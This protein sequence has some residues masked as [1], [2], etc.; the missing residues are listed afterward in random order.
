MR[1]I[2]QHSPRRAHPTHSD[3]TEARHRAAELR[4]LIAEHDHRY[5]VLN[6]PVIAD[7]TYDELKRE[8]VGIEE[9]FRDL[10]TSDSPTRHIGGRPMDGFAKLQHETPML[11]LRSVWDEEEIRH[12]Y[13]NCCRE[14][15]TQTCTLVGESKLDGTSVELTYDDGHLVSASTRGDGHY[16]EDVT[17]NIQMIRDVPLIL[18][19]R[20]AFTQR[21]EKAIPVPRHLVVRGEVFMHKSQFA[22][23][24]A[25][26]T[27]LGEKT[28]ATPR[29]AAAGSLLHVDPGITAGRFLHI[30]F[31]EMAP[32]TQDRPATQWECL[33]AMRSLGLNTDPS[34]VRLES[35]DEA[36][37]WFKRMMARRERFPNEVDGCVFKIDDLAAQQQLGARVD[38]PRWAVAWKF[39]PLQYMTHVERIQTYV[40]RAGIL[41]PVA[42]LAPVRIGG[43]EVS[44]VALGSQAEIERNDIRIGDTVLVELSG[45]VMPRMVKVVPERRTGGERR[46]HA[47]ERCPV[48][49]SQIVHVEGEAAARCPNTSCPARLREAIHHFTSKDAMNIR[50]LGEKLIDHLVTEHVVTN[51]A[52]IYNLKLRELTTHIGMDRKR[53]MNLLASIRRSALNAKLDRLLFALGLP[54]LDRKTAADLAAK[55]PTLNKFSGIDASDLTGAGFE[56][57]VASMISNW[58]SNQANRRMVQRLRCAGIDPRTRPKVTR[59]LAGKS[60]VF[61]GEFESLTREQAAQAVVAQGGKVSGNISDHT[62]FVVAGTHPRAN[63]IREARI[64]AAKMIDESEFRRLAL[65]A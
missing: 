64:H 38:S 32:A 26:R 51:L 8:L 3:R 7:A 27:E 24:N 20:R 42:Q 37:R 45:G 63:K 43:V 65:A 55:F 25:R 29:H 18:P 52:D 22:R 49:G 13:A 5:H 53:A 34:A 36:V 61:T 28:F 19:H 33:E 4:Q 21:T 40:S 54:R 23:L 31:W 62:D 47:P 2:L 14:L 60:F 59:R 15:G 35:A 56:A 16:G 44:Y 17:A 6:V 48:C 10:I 11:S 1:T 57:N 9:R 30:L 58:F 39:P 41:T 12:F 50:G 46:Y